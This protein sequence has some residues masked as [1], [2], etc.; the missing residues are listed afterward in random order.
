LPEVLEDAENELT[1]RARELIASLLAELR[2]L[3]ERIKPYAQAIELASVES[4]T[5]QR[6]RSIPNRV[7]VLW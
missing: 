1:V 3:E 6:L 2:D 4:S 7:H 5:C